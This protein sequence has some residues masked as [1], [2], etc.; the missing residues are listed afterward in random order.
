MAVYGARRVL[1]GILCECVC[2]GVGVYVAVDVVVVV[3]V[4]MEMGAGMGAGG[5][6]D[7][8][9]GV[10]TDVEGPACSL[11]DGGRRM[12]PPLVE[13]LCPSTVHGSFTCVSASTRTGV[14]LSRGDI[15]YPYRSEYLARG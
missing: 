1:E 5:K 4:D 6:A 11:G 13:A 14:A 3:V 10:D 7:V 9:V 12:C 8:G 15:A 2:V